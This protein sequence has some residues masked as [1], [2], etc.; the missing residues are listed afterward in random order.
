VRRVASMVIAVLIG[1]GST[2]PS[3]FAAPKILENTDLLPLASV[4]GPTIAGVP[5]AGRAWSI[6]RGSKAKVD[7]DGEV[8]VTIHGL[9]F[10]DTGTTIPQMKAS[11]ACGGA[12]VG[13]TGLVA[14]SAD[15]DAEIRDTLSLPKTCADPIILIQTPGG[16]WI[17]STLIP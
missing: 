6:S 16:A 11:V 10:A 7:D 4:P 5:G 17:A 2:T 12:V 1:V 3:A 15:G 13:T 9:V 8:K 14:T